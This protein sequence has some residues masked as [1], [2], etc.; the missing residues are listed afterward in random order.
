MRYRLSEHDTRAFYRAI[1]RR[2]GEALHMGRAKNLTS[3][4]F[5]RV[6]GLARVL[7]AKRV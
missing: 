3:R 4:V 6:K 7:V 1:K 2:P 5:I